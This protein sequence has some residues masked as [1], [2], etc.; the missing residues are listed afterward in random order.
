MSSKIAG[1]ERQENVSSKG[2][3]QKCQVGASIKKGRQVRVSRKSVKQGRPTKKGHVQKGRES[4]KRVQ[5]ACPTR[6]SSK[7][8][9]QERQVRVSHMSVKSECPTKASR[10]SAPQVPNRSAKSGCLTVCQV[11]VWDKCVHKM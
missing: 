7:V 4:D 8:V 9:L 10:K 11:G 5:R 6:L 3:S 2:V 1:Q